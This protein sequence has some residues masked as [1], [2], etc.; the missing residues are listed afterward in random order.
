MDESTADPELHLAK[1]GQATPAQE[2]RICCFTTVFKDWD[3]LKDIP[4][5]FREEGVDYYCFTDDPELRSDSWEVVYVGPV[6]DG[7]EENRRYKILFVHPLQQQGYDFYLYLD[8]TLFVR[9]K[10]SQL[11]DILQIARCDLVSLYYTETRRP[12]NGLLAIRNNETFKQFAK[13]W[14]E[15]MMSND[16][17]MP[18]GRVRDEYVY[19]EAVS[20][21]PEL[22]LN[23]IPYLSLPQYA[24]TIHH[25]H[26]S[27]SPSLEKRVLA[28][29]P[30]Y[31]LG[32]LSVPIYFLGGFVF[33]R[34]KLAWLK[35]TW[36]KARSWV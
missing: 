17:R 33:R 8:A 3:Y 7:R 27:I 23:L 4:E 28:D 16:R 6:E 18:D 36:E 30:L 12:W 14:H 10:L 2:R 5:P 13:T 35:R 11:V 34:N 20:Q 31:R 25:K 9:S 32:W 22:R 29:L 1:W 24:M 26:L 21:N 15:M 19:W